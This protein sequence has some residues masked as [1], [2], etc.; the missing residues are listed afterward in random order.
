MNDT[1]SLLTKLSSEMMKWLYIFHRNDLVKNS[2]PY[3]S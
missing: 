2:T 3:I 1:E